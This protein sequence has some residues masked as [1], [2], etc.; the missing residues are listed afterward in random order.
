M[1]L[2]ASITF[3]PSINHA[4]IGNWLF[5]IASWIVVFL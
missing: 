1:F 5:E 4:I 2:A 3:L